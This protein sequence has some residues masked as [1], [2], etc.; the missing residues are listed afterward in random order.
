[1]PQLQHSKILRLLAVVKLSCLSIGRAFKL[2]FYSNLQFRQFFATLHTHSYVQRYKYMHTL[3]FACS[4]IK[5]HETLQPLCAY[6]KI[7]QN[8]NFKDSAY[9]IQ[10]YL[11]VL[12]E[13]MYN[14]LSSLNCSLLQKILLLQTYFSKCSI[15]CV[16]TRNNL[17]VNSQF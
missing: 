4:K 11:V 17:L 16:Y 6:L 8:R 13:R 2:H 7:T 15:T 10:T 1:M 12:K 5:Y 9:K 3:H 14:L